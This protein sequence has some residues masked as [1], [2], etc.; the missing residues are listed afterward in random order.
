MILNLA[1]LADEFPAKLHNYHFDVQVAGEE[2]YFRLQIKKRRLHQHER[3]FINEEDRDR[4]II[5]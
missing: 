2:L 1:K 5:T 3:L 4:I